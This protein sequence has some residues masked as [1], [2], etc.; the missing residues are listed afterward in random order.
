[1]LARLADL[2]DEATTAFDAYDYARA[3]ER[4][5][6]FFWE[7]CDEYLELVK[8]RAYGGR[9]DEAAWSAQAAL[10]LALSTLLRLFAPFLPFVTEEVWSWWQEGSVHTAAV[11]RRLGAARRRRRRR[12][13]R[14]R[15]GRR[16]ARRDPQGQDRGQALAQV[17]GR[18]RGGGRPRAA[19]RRPSSRSST[20]CAR[21]PTPPSLSVSVAAE[22]TITVELAPE[23]DEPAEA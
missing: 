10:Q 18:H 17:A 16:R 22:A 6:T 9:G 4:T 23:P 7:F 5:E 20:T 13:A 21:P 11:A 8:G 2:V 1:M 12:P 19:G 3:L 14:L 15:H